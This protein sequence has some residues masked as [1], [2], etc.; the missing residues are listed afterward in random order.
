MKSFRVVLDF[1]TGGADLQP[2]EVKDLLLEQWE[3]TAAH[4]EGDVIDVIAVVYQDG[5]ESS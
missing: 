2:S 5:K 3:Q 4:G 1:K